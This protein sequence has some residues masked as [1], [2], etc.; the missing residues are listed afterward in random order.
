VTSYLT[1]DTL[2][3]IAERA[4]PGVLVRDAGLLESA[5]ARPAATAFGEEAY[6]DLFTK[7]GALLHSLARNHALVDGNKRLSWLATVTFLALNNQWV[8]AP[9]DDAFD[10]VMAVAA[11]GVSDPDKIGRALQGWSASRRVS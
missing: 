10:L 8:D 1:L 7:A 4:V 9:D 2:L 6:P 5:L 3:Q 11:G